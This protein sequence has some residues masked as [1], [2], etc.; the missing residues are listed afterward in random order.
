MTQTVYLHVVYKHPNKHIKQVDQMFALQSFI[1]EMLLFL[2]A[3]H[4]KFVQ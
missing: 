4:Y 1:E 2:L 3:F